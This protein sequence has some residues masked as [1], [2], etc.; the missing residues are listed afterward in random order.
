MGKRVVLL[1]L[2]QPPNE[3]CLILIL[4]GLPFS[5]QQNPSSSNDSLELRPASV[6]V[7]GLTS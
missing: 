1:A 2:I 4:S 3:P 7:L 5:P 6:G